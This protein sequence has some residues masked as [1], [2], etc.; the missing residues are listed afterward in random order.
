MAEAVALVGLF[1][2]IAQFIEY[3]ARLMDRLEEISSSVNDR[4]NALTAIRVRLPA[5]LGIIQR[6]KKQVENQ[7]LDISEAQTLLPVIENT[8]AHVKSML[9]IIKKSTPPKKGSFV[10]KY[11]KA[12]RSLSLDAE[13]QRISNRLQD[14]LQIISLF[15]TTSLVESTRQ[16]YPSIPT[17][18]NIC[19]PRG[20]AATS[21]AHFVPGDDLHHPSLTRADETPTSISDADKVDIQLS[22]SNR[23]ATSE[24]GN[25]SVDHQDTERPPYS[26][27]PTDTASARR[28]T[29]RCA[30]SCSCVCHRPYQLSTPSFLTNLMG[31][32]SVNYGG[33]AFVKVPCNERNCK[34]RKESAARMT[35]R[36]PNW[37]LDRVVHLALSSGA[38]NTKVNL[39]TMRV[40]PDSA[41]VFAVISRGD[42]D[43]LRDLFKSGQASIYDVS[44]SNWTLVHTAFTLGRK[45]IC[46]FLISEGADLTIDAANGSNVIERAWFLA[47]KSSKTPGDYVMCDNEVLREVDLD[48][49]VSSQQYNLIHKIVLGISKLKLSEV[50]ETSTSGIDGKDIRGATALWW[51]SAQ[52]NTR[53]VRTLLE[54]GA[55]HATGGAMSQTPLHVARNAETV[56][57]LLEH[58]AEVDP[59]DTA[60]RTPLHCFC[61]RQVGASPSIVREI[62]KGGA[63]VDVTAYGGQTPLH[64]STMFGNT[65]LIPTLLEFGANINA[66]KD[67]DVTPLMA[68]VRYEQQ[69]A[70]SCLLENRADGTIKNKHCQNILHV[71]AIYAGPGCMNVLACSNIEGLD[72]NAKDAKGFTPA[73]YFESRKFRFDELEIA[74]H[75]LVAAFAAANLDEADGGHENLD[76]TDDGHENGDGVT[77]QRTGIC[78]EYFVMPGSF[79]ST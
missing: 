70:V 73:E 30:S 14:N 69:D 59:R 39:N 3:G 12:M 36:F 24:S 78:D 77:G 79:A 22:I 65:A 7:F 47:Q 10:A 5:V 29:D 53:A 18:G 19:V 37:A 26:A 62:L 6:I 33:Q 66:L 35:Y 55:S 76:E 13:V 52:G 58:N 20:V 46:R 57:V 75:N 67:E 50:L 43:K 45:D 23:A 25:T 15:Q 21:S 27:F 60:G 17:P 74:F 42:I 49:F 56:R 63:A 48:D 71:A 68:G 9:A 32:L 28:S 38:L 61:Y 11:V 41:E 16:T 44:R 54:N 34:R 8:N 4:P 64:Y 1:A 2:A 40:L 31:H 72:P 51:A